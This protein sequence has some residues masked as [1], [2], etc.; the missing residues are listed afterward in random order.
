MSS[1]RSFTLAASALLAAAV[2]AASSGQDM[3]ATP[4]YGT[5]NL[6]TQYFYDKSNNLTRKIDARSFSTWYVYDADNRVTH[7]IDALGG[8]TQ[9]TYDAEDRVIATRRY[10][11]SISTATVAGF[12]NIVTTSNFSIST[13]GLDRV[14][15]SFFDRDG[16][17]AYTIDTAGTVTQIS[18]T[19][20]RQKNILQP[21]P[22]STLRRSGSWEEVT[23]VTW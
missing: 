5:L 19:A 10:S 11:A 12:G 17:E 7:T 15:R 13:G 20:W 1:F 16:R 8:V 21:F 2:P 6:R 4:N 9:S 3:N 18:R 22:I 14:S 23:G